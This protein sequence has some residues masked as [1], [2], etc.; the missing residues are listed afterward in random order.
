MYLLS[1]LFFWDVHLWIK[2][3]RT[4]NSLKMFLLNIRTKANFV[5]AKYSKENPSFYFNHII[6][7]TTK[8]TSFYSLFYFSPINTLYVIR[9]TKQFILF[10]KTLFFKCQISTL[11]DLNFKYSLSIHFTFIKLVWDGRY[12][13]VVWKKT[14]W[15][16]NECE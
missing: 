5:M 10:M 4:K 14:Y 6:W 16:K 13:M 9:I 8:W 2:K 12:G 15:L 1:K 7:K 3:K 11:F